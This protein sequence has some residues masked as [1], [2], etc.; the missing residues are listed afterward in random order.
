MVQ[1]KQGV[2][3]KQIS[4]AEAKFIRKDGSFPIFIRESILPMW[5]AWKG[6]SFEGIQYE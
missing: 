5:K 6:V 3:E 4:R 2:Q 1:W